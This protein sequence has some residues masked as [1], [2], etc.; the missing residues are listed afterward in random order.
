MDRFNPL[1]VGFTLLGIAGLLVTVLCPWWRY[2]L[3]EDLMAVAHHD[4]WIPNLETYVGMVPLWDIRGY[5]V[6]DWLP[7]NIIQGLGVVAWWGLGMVWAAREQER[8]AREAQEV[9][10]D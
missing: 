5:E 6:A 1:R 8:L 2:R 4:L 9:G 10:A 7:F 3:E